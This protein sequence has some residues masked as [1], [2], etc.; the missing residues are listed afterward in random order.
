LDNKKYEK[1]LPVFVCCRKYI[2]SSGR[3]FFKYKK[4]QTVFCEVISLLLMQYI[5]Y[6]SWWFLRPLTFEVISWFKLHGPS[7]V[8]KKREKK[9]I[10]YEKVSSGRKNRGYE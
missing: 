8:P 10:N 9:L 2:S 6:D 5:S 4:I 1:T 3:Y 7:F